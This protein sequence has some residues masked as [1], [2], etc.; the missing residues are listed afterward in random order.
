M[1]VLLMLRQG[2]QPY[3]HR[4]IEGEWMLVLTFKLR[5]MRDRV[6]QAL[7]GVV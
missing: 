4:E 7:L 1:M 5:S 6:A 2:S 3:M